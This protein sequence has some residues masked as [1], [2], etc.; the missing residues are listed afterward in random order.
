MATDEAT[1]VVMVMVMVTAA[2]MAAAM[3]MAMAMAMA[4]ARV[5]D[6]DVE[7]MAEKVFFFVTEAALEVTATAVV[8]S[9]RGDRWW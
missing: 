9:G 7:A 3:A 6:V 2:A 4:A 5:V 1:K 8:R